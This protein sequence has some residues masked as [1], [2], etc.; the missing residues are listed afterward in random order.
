MTFTIY[1]AIDI[2]GGKCVR[3]FQGDFNQETVY[4][5]SPHDIARMWS[6]SGASW[7]HVVDLDGAKEGSP[8]H[9]QLIGEMVKSI[10]VPIQVGGGIRTLQDIEA[11]VE[12][13]IARIILGTAAIEDLIF[14][15]EALRRYGS[16]IAIGLDCRSGYVATRGW[17]STTKMKATELAKQLV[18]YGAELFIYTDIGRDGTLTGPNIEEIVQLGVATGKKVIASGGVGHLNDLL[19]LAKQ[20][21]CGVEGAIVGKALYTEAISL[22]EALD[23]VREVKRTC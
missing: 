17:L 10:S 18:E 12:C 6:E 11:Y 23:K 8:V 22:P 14:T 7:V 15:K 16:R 9:F 19:A 5:E 4:G 2:R 3:L 1:P 13:G 20:R 21:E